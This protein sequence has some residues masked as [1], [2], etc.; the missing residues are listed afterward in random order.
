MGNKGRNDRSSTGIREE[1]KEK[2]E[3]KK[4]LGMGFVYMSK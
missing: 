2:E 4:N 3:I 1:S